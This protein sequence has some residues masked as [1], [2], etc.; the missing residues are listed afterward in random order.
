[1]RFA[2]FEPFPTP[3]AL[4]SPFDTPLKALNPYSLQPRAYASRHPNIVPKHRYNVRNL[5]ISARTYEI[6]ALF[7]EKKCSEWTSEARTSQ[8]DTA[9]WGEH[10]GTEPNF[11]PHHTSRAQNTQTTVFQFL[12]F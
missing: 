4:A 10:F 9:P 8:S 5:I 11:N 3:L 7:L 1:M 12:N 2:L 6:W